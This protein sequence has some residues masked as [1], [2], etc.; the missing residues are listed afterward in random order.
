MDEILGLIQSLADQISDEPS[1]VLSDH[2]LQAE[3]S[4]SQRA[5]EPKA[6]THQIVE[7]AIPLENQR[8][9][10]TP[11]ELMPK[12]QDSKGWAQPHE[13]PRDVGVP[14][15]ILQ[16]PVSRGGDAM[17][18]SPD[19]VVAATAN[20]FLK[21]AIRGEQA[22]PESKP[23]VYTQTIDPERKV[24]YIMPG[25]EE[26]IDFA[27]AFADLDARIQLPAVGADNEIAASLPELGEPGPEPISSEQLVADSMTRVLQSDSAMDRMGYL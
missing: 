26:D 19:R 5:E 22:Q 12:P 27:N 8:I 1:E 24:Q 9:L 7:S 25:T 14:V 23:Q 17:V 4:L 6:P 11:A 15:E 3:A 21:E 13:Q 18:V 20:I 2:L 10:A 16:R